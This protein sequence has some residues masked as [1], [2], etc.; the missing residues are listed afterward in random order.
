[1]DYINEL[2]K[3]EGKVHQ[4]I[5]IRRLDEINLVIAKDQTTHYSVSLYSL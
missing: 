1:M 2:R 4:T 3:L 5:G